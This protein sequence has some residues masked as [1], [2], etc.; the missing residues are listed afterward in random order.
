[1]MGGGGERGGGGVGIEDTDYCPG[2]DGHNHHHHPTPAGLIR[3]LRVYYRMMMA[4]KLV[5]D[6]R[7]GYDLVIGVLDELTET[8][9][10]LLDR[11]KP[12]PL[13]P[14]DFYGRR[15]APE[16]EITNPAGFIY[17]MVHEAAVEME[18]AADDVGLVDADPRDTRAAKPTLL[19]RLRAING[20][21]G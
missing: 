15:P 17:R 12:G 10:L 19:P 4:R 6:P 2:I 20:E 8:Y 7:I 16:P 3:H 1:M 18:S 21:D 9:G 13:P 11:P 5:D 14:Y